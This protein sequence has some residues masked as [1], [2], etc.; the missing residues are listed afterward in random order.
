MERKVGRPRLAHSLVVQRQ[1]KLS[2]EDSTRFD[3]R[4]RAQGVSPAEAMRKLVKGFVNGVYAIQMT[5]L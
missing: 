3:E 5:L 2:D 4:A 1:V